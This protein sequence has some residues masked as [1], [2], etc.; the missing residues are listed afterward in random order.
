MVSYG[1]RW[2]GYVRLRHPLTPLSATIEHVTTR[3]APKKVGRP[4]A[5]YSQASRLLR[6]YE[7]LHHRQYVT[8][9]QLMELFSVDR[10]T[11]QRDLNVLQDIVA[12]EED[13]RTPENEKRFRPASTRK[14]EM[15]RITMG[16]MIALYMGRNV[17]AFTEGT[18]LKRSIDSLYDK[19]SLRLAS[20]RDN[21]RAA[22]PKKFHCTVGSPRSYASADGVLDDV[23][24]GIVSERRIAMTY[25]R[26]G[27]KSYVDTLDPYTLVLHNHALFVVGRSQYANA[28]R[29]FA[30]E[31]I[32]TTDLGQETFIVPADY[33][34]SQFFSGA[35]GIIVG[36]DPCEV[37]VRFDAKVAPYVRSRLW[38]PSMR[39]RDVDDGAIEVSLRV[40]VTEELLHWI[41]GYGKSASVVAPDMLAAKLAERRG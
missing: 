27:K 28:V 16:E 24:E 11:I 34:P 25:K 41:C 31:R 30:L 5:E 3:L 4:K 23:V 12:V 6:M 8:I 14:V 38:H 10:R 32:A 33:D 9:P 7:L 22:L 1:G 37:V 2:T 36:E 26:P 40:G 18:D 15:F 35:F 13:G 39:V 19:L 21:V 29:T 17:F 20:R